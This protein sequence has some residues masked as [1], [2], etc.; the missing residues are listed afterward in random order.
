MYAGYWIALL[1]WH[2]V[3]RSVKTVSHGRLTTPL[4]APYADPLLPR[5]VYTF[6]D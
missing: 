5:Y 4:S 6:I 1:L 3:T 2:V